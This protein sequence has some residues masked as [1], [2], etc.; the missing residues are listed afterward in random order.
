[1]KYVGAHVSAAGGVSNAPVNATNI[2][3][4]A[5]ALFTRNQKRWQA[6]PLA[7]EEIHAFK[8]ALA[9]SGIPVTAVL[10]HAGY[11]INP[12]HPDPEKRQK[13]LDAL[14]DDVLR[15]EA[16]GLTALNLHPGSHLGLVSEEECF[17]I[18]AASLSQFLKISPTVSPV[19]ETTAG[20]G[21]MVGHRFEHLA[22]IIRRTDQPD[23]VGVCID[24]SHIFA[25]GYD[26]STADGFRA[27]MDEFERIVGFNRLK[28]VHLNDSKTLMGSRVDRHARLGEGEIGIE[29][30]RLIMNDERFDGIPLVL[31]TP[32][33]EKYAEEIALL[34]SLDERGRISSPAAR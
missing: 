18:I 9:A 30:F 2:G 20:Q 24:T 7:E 19:I 10:P 14:E 25:A 21:N 4:R 15:T 31:E 11:L 8:E 12:G 22:E 17:D 23:R 27:V 3:A 28:G 5:F 16:L 26:I 32:D 33:P 6:P 13:S 29:A 1:M 34:Y